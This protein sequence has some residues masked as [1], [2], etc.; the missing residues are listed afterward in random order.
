MKKH[1]P[2]LRLALLGLAGCAAACSTEPEAVGPASSEAEIV[3][4]PQLSDDTRV[5][6][7]GTSYAWQEN[8]LAGVFIAAATPTTN[9]RGTLKRAPD[10][11]AYFSATVKASKSGDKVYAYYPYSAVNPKNADD[12]LCLPLA[13]EQTQSQANVFNGTQLPMAATAV[14]LTSDLAKN[15]TAALTLRFS[16]V[17]TIAQFSLWSSNAAYTAERVHSV[18]FSASDT[19]LASGAA[20]EGL[21]VPIAG[22]LEGSITCNVSAL[23]SHSV[24][25]ALDSPFS[26]GRTAAEARSAYL[27]VPAAEASGTLRAIVR[28]DAAY[29]EFTVEKGM[30]GVVFTRNSVKIFSLDLARAVRTEAPM[31]RVTVVWQPAEKVAQ[32]GGASV[33]NVPIAIT[34]S[35]G[36]TAVY[37]AFA[38]RAELPADLEADLLA[39]GTRV[40]K[41]NN[42]TIK[43]WCEGIRTDD[44]VW[45]AYAMGVGNDGSH[46]QVIEAQLNPA[47]LD[48]SA[49]EV[50]FYRTI[51]TRLTDG[52][53]YGNPDP[54]VPY[55][56][57]GCYIKIG[58]EI[59]AQ[60]TVVSYKMYWGL[61]SEMQYLSQ[62][63]LIALANSKG[64]ETVVVAEENPKE[65]PLYV[66]DYE[67]TATVF[68]WKDNLGWEHLYKG[69]IVRSYR[70]GEFVGTQVWK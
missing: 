66:V 10:Q 15:S 21:T 69:D 58:Y 42:G 3:L 61:Y 28:T 38:P 44:A 56:D 27:V 33:Y 8:D 43:A 50:P 39:S 67:T 60:S 62:D 9:S 48:P 13:A 7:N 54:S 1:L 19:P 26:P 53:A 12:C 30:Q 5:T 35:A 29:Y 37:Y 70:N 51:K 22:L 2:L 31:P 64:S 47:Q 18:T 24:K 17:A 45:V 20:G 4:Y 55:K 52:A 59:E 25:V 65:L 40:T 6:L 16:P 46:S 49:P 23:T 68:V 34:P 63:E 36:C 14:A 11:T 41:W 57:G 32:E